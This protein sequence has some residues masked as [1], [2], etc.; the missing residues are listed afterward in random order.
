[1]W[2]FLFNPSQHLPISILY[3]KN[4]DYFLKTHA[5]IS[6]DKTKIILYSL[7]CYVLF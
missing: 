1:M 4:N 7:I 5:F 3:L 6:S 2:V